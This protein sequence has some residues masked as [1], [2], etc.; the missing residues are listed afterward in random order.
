MRWVGRGGGTMLHLPGQVACNP[1]L[2]LDGIG[3]S[4]AGYVRELQEVVVELL[5]DYRLAATLDPGHPGV[6]VNGRLVAHIGVAVRDG[7]SA[8]GLVVNADPD[9]EPFRDVRCDGDPTPMTSLQREAAGRVRVAGVRQRLVELVAARFGFDRVSV[10][11]ALPGALPQ[12]TR[13][14][15]PQR[16]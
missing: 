3:L 7:V 10:F 16:S 1:I 12:A 5:G 13:H 11:H 2:P 9:L 8:F 15:A 4:V 14:A 6:H